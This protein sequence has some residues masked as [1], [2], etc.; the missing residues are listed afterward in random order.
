MKANEARK[1]LGI[2][3]PTLYKYVREGKISVTRIN[4]CHQIYNEGDVYALIGRKSKQKDQKIISYSRVST[5]SQKSQLQSQTTRLLDFCCAKALDLH[6]QY[7]DIGSGMKGNR[8]A[9]QE[10]IQEVIGGTVSVVVIENK[11]RLTRFGFE[12]LETIFKFFGTKILVVSDLTEK[13]YEQELTE[14]LIAIIHH[15]SMK[16]YRHRRVLKKLAQELKNENS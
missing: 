8:E 12:Q 1:I 16:M 4:K 10:V 14:D 7:S 2:T 6:K 5:H 9:F 15:F 3:Y 11:D 13:S